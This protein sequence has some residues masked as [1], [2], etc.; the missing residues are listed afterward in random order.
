MKESPVN[1]RRSTKNSKGTPSRMG[2]PP[3]RMAILMVNGTF[4]YKNRLWIELSLERILRH[5]SLLTDFKVFLWN[6]D[7]ENP[8]VLRYLDSKR[9][10]VEVFNED[11]FNVDDWPGVRS[12]PDPGRY[13]YF[14]RG[15]H[16]HRGA[17]HIL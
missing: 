13:D 2:R 3:L 8:S 9:N 4:N 12:D 14:S 16:V 11:N 6:H 15:V 7:R 17:L 1:W 10:Y 5:T